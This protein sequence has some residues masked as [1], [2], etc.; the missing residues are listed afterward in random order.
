MTDMSG[1]AIL[2][3]LGRVA[4][5]SDLRREKRHLFHVDMSAAALGRRLAQVSQLRLLCA[6]LNR[7]DKL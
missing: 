7:A 6:E 1:V 5:L 4:E 3:R 2:A